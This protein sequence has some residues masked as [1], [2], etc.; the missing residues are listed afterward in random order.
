LVELSRVELEFTLNPGEYQK[1]NR[2]HM[3]AYAKPRT[4]VA[5]LAN[6]GGIAVYA[7]FFGGTC[8][9]LRPLTPAGI[10]SV[11]ISLLLVLTAFA[12]MPAYRYFMV[13]SLSKHPTAGRPVKLEITDQFL[14]TFSTRF[15]QTVEW[16]FIRDFKV[17]KNYI[18]ITI[19]NNRALAIRLSAFSSEDQLNEFRR[20]LSQY[21]AVSKP[22]DAIVAAPVND[23]SVWPPSPKTARIVSEAFL[24]SAGVLD[25][26]RCFGRL[27]FSGEVTVLD[28]T[29]LPADI[30]YFMFRFL[31]VYNIPAIFA[32]SAAITSMVTLVLATYADT[33][34]KAIAMSAGIVF[35]MTALFYWSVYRATKKQIYKNNPPM[36]VTQFKT[37]FRRMIVATGVICINYDCRYLESVSLTRRGIF[38][39][40]Y[41]G[42]SEFLPARSFAGETEM[43][44][45]YLRMKEAISADFDKL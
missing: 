16:S 23:E 1:L 30:L 2:E 39:R 42:V 38:T 37:D 12:T 13:R 4:F 41:I 29:L 31:G 25:E 24:D 8:V 18:F 27:I 3:R 40:C 19:S 10:A 14:K 9:S 15:D 28:T 45:F 5:A 43:E 6:Y 44:R 34:A 22:I 32:V 33:I 11:G 20:L 36:P 35:G 26:A 21:I 7:L 17:S